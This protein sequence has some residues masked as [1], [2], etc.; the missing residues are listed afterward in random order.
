MQS[1]VVLKR[2]G[3]LR[4]HGNGGDNG[5][6]SY[7]EAMH[8]SGVL[9]QNIACEEHYLYWSECMFINVEE[10]VF[11]QQVSDRSGFKVPAKH[12]SETYSIEGSN[13]LHSC[14]SRNASD[15]EGPFFHY[16]RGAYQWV[17]GSHRYCSSHQNYRRKRKY[18]HSRKLNSIFLRKYTFIRSIQARGS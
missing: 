11:C 14:T 4:H 6:G 9:R 16:A 17:V 12:A 2:E 7:T 15:L 18:R 1:T 5:D 13:V 8:D 10:D 3:E